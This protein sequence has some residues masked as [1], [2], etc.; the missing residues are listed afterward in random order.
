[1]RILIVVATGMEVAPVVAKLLLASEKGPRLNAYAYL[2]HNVDVLTTGVGMVATSA[3]C[4]HAI[5]HSY[6]DLAL[7]FGVCGSFD[8][9]CRPGDVVY[10]RSDRIAELGAEDDEAFLTAQELGLVGED[11][12]PSTCGQLLN[13]EPP[14][15]PIIRRLRAVDGITVN[16]AHGRDR[17]IAAVRAR[18]NPHVESMEGAAFA[19][20]CLIHRLPHAQVRAV[21]NMVEKRNLDAWK[22]DDAIVNLGQTALSILDHA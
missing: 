1:M 17:S 20:A 15:N 8:P 14:D 12:F 13:L 7:N 22:L 3:W 2:A 11:E 16:T 6:Y 18:F 4:S 9:E 21:S 10:V 19:Y 5:G